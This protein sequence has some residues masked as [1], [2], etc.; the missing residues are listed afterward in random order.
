MDLFDNHMNAYD[1]LD[2]MGIKELFN[3]SEEAMFMEEMGKLANQNQTSEIVASVF[4][5]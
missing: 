2:H 4:F 3:E 5:S 1:V